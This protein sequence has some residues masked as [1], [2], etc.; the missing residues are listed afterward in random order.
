MR[1]RGPIPALVVLGT[2]IGCD[3]QPTALTA[4]GP[5]LGTPAF[6]IVDAAH[7]GSAP[8]YFLPP[9][10]PM[11]SY[12]GTFDGTQSP[13]VR[14]CELAAGACG[15]TIVT[16]SGTQIKV[17]AVAE[18]YSL[19]WKTKDAGLDPTKTYRI[20]VAL[21]TQVLGYADVVVLSNGSQIKTVDKNQFVATINGGTLLIKFRIERG[22]VPPPPPPPCTPGTQGCGWENGHIISYTQTSWGDALAAGGMQLIANYDLVYVATSGFAEVGIP[23]AAGHSV[24]FTNAVAVLN[25]LPASGLPAPLNAD[26]VDPTSSASGIFGGE[27]L[28]LRFNIDFSDWGFTLGTSSVPFGDLRLCGLTGSLAGLNDLSIRDYSAIVNTALGG[29]STPYS[30]ADLNSTTLQIN[31]S[32]L[33]GV[34]SAFAQQH[35][36]PFGC[37]WRLRDVITYSQTSWG[38]PSFPGGPLLVAHYDAVFVNDFG[39]IEVGIA[40]TQGFSIIFTSSTEVLDYLPATGIAAPLNADLV[41]PLSS[42][43]GVFGGEVLALRINI[44]F[45]DA[46]YTLGD[47]GVRFGDLTLC[48]LTGAVAGLNGT[49]VRAFSS[50]A[51]TTLG[52]G[53]TPYSISDVNQ[54]A[55]DINNAFNNGLPNPFAQQHLVNGPCP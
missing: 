12:S 19:I 18:A 2:I 55:F 21:G 7:G 49:S 30:I 53:S 45:A 24:T 6:T 13:T 43:S 52:G 32:F 50:I 33:D 28:A 11:P 4:S 16:W 26:L 42:V 10:V 5:D 17:D 39:M 37:R 22:A 3:Y 40:G 1:H 54:K 25:Y 51:N 36:R 48:G 46:G 47:A 23:G 34:P 31:G 38:E 15:L 8:F 41:G 14:V 44:D 35:L 20:K 27:V 29:G 9:M